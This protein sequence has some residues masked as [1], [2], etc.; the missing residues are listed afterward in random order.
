MTNETKTV[1]KKTVARIIGLGGII[2]AVGTWYVTFFHAYTHGYEAVVRINTIGEAT[3][4]L[5][6]CLIFIPFIVFVLYEYMTK[7][8]TQ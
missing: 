8:L 7:V 1:N 3:A 5:I 6:L 4:E 2:A